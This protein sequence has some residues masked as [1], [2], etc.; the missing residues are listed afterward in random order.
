MKKNVK[1]ESQASHTEESLYK[2]LEELIS[3][4]DNNR[5]QTPCRRKSSGIR[6]AGESTGTGFRK[7]DF[8]V[9]LFTFSG[10]GAS[11]T[12]PVFVLLFI[13]AFMHICTL[14]FNVFLYGF[15]GDTPR[16]R[17]KVGRRPERHIPIQELLHIGVICRMGMYFPGELG[18][19]APYH[20]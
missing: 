5:A 1:I 7:R 10:P 17:N 8:T 13:L 9:P 20:Q 3:Q 4:Y 16:G 15:H 19:Q 11:F 6:P 12:P 18:L 2:K 14:S